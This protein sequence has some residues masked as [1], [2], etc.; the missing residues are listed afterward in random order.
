[1]LFIATKYFF[2]Q[3]DKKTTQTESKGRLINTGFFKMGG[4]LKANSF[5]QKTCLDWGD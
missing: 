2:Q 1:M 4:K 5:I 3:P